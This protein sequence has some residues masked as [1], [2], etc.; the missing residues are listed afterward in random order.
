MWR[1]LNPNSHHINPYHT[2]TLLLYFV[3]QCVSGIN[4]VTLLQ[5]SPWQITC[6]IAA[7][8]VKRWQHCGC[9]FFEVLMTVLSIEVVEPSVVTSNAFNCFAKQ[10]VMYCN[11][12]EMN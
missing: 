4:G 1:S 7:A 9:H 2:L 6:M 8:M 10:S 5:L 3:R 11:Y 12:C